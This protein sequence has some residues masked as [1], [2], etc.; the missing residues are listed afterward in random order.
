MLLLAVHPARHNQKDHF[1]RVHR[2]ILRTLQVE[3]QPQICSRQNPQQTE[4]QQSLL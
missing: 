3:I 4:P 1:H 2:A